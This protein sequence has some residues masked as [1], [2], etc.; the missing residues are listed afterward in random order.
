MDPA[1]FRDRCVIFIKGTTEHVSTDLK[2]RGIMSRNVN[3]SKL[4]FN[5]NQ[6]YNIYSTCICES[7]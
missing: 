7:S 2:I 5:S 6:Y 3:S 4:N 1:F